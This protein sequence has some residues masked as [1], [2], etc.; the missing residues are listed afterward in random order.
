MNWTRE[1]KDTA[2]RNKFGPRVE[3]L[4]DRTVPTATVTQSGNFI[5]ITGIGNSNNTIRITDN[6]LNSAGAIQ[7]TGTIL[8]G[9]F[10]STAVTPGAPIIVVINTK[11]GKD[12]VTYNVT[13]SFNRF[14]PGSAPATIQSPTGGRIINALLGAG[15]DSFA[16]T[17]NDPTVTADPGGG[18]AATSGPRFG[19]KGF[20][21]V[22]ST[23]QVLVNG[24]SGKD[25]IGINFA[26]DI[27]NGS[28]NLQAFGGADDDL[29][30]ITEDVDGANNSSTN[31]ALVDGG[32]GQN[33]LG[34]ILYQNQFFTGP[35]PSFL[36]TPYT[37]STGRLQGR[38]G[39]TAVVT[40]NVLVSGV[41]FKD[42]IQL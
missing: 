20:D 29:C 35:S 17:G 28:V 6:G 2:T 42:I 4:E 23:L 34:L 40:S 16:F 8:G 3:A 31:N 36:P 1:R 7:I 33:T 37:G 12:T 9:N 19:P 38:H 30:Y 25:K 11:G 27:R 21:V 26:G 15:D 41:S 13:G 5:S 24:G 22:N 18:F 32:T 14:V 39:D 10:T